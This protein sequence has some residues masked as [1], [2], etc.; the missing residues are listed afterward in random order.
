[1]SLEGACLRMSGTTASPGV[2][3]VLGALRRDEHASA[4]C[5]H[6]L[7]YQRAGAGATVSQPDFET[8]NAAYAVLIAPG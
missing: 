1:M 6:A 2:S 7:A 5:G 4:P 8:M 3:D